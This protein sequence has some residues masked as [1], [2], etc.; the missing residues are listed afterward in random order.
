MKRWQIEQIL[1]LN[2]I[3]K[4]K[5]MVHPQHQFIGQS[6]LHIEKRENYLLKSIRKG[7]NFLLRIL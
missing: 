6:L 5:L 3:G 2:D 7:V 4:D 1:Y